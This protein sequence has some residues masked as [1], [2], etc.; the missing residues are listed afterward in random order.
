MVD[1]VL[2]SSIRDW[3]LLPIVAIMVLV[4]LLRHYATVMMKADPKTDDKALRQKMILQ[5]ARMLR[6]N[7]GH[8][9]PQVFA[10]R[11]ELFT[12]PNTGLLTQKVD[13]PN[14]MANMMSDPTMMMDMMKRNMVMIVPNIVLIPGMSYF[15][16]GVVIAKFPFALTSRFR[17]MLQ[18]DIELSTVDV[19]Y[20]TSLSMYFLLFFGLR[21]LFSLL[22]GEESE[23][24]EAAMMQQQM[25]GGAPAA[26]MTKVFKAEADNMTLAEHRW[27]L[28]DVEQWILTQ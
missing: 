15:F 4:G 14:P 8:L 16:S 20:V 12:K 3:V 23:A 10:A 22:L 25:G 17:S 19:T 27:H 1:L 9:P 18:R 6:E 2:D 26:D 13:A 24:D 5:R 28:N 21:G 7:G 11:K